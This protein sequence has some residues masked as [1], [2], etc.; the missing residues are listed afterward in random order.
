M[1]L[2]L[3]FLLLTSSPQIDS[4]KVD[5]SENAKI[6]FYESKISQLET[7]VNLTDKYLD[8]IT[9][10]VFWSLSV[11]GGIAALLVGFGW[12]SNFKVYQRDKKALREEL[13]NIIGTSLEKQENL[14]SQRL[15][16]IPSEIDSQID[17]LKEE[18]NSES[19]KHVE[20]SF[21]ELKSEI[22]NLKASVNSLK[23]KY[24]DLRLKD[25]D[26]KRRYWEIKDVPSNELM[27]CVRIME[28]ATELNK[29][30]AISSSIDRVRAI[31]KD[32]H[33]IYHGDEFELVEV[34]DSL[35]EKY[36][37]GVNS[38]KTLL[39]ESQQKS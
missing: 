5:S 28:L 38:I 27:D 2:F 14:I 22:N 1:S 11:L 10:T 39:R 25:L 20:N 18:V 19:K 3:C 8:R 33:N 30:H 9:N 23:T 17:S 35:P 34:L 12:F 29:D 15:S 24:K 36:S 37:E 31:L 32:G 13:E 26:M 6:E 16:K 4:T 7:Q 21:D